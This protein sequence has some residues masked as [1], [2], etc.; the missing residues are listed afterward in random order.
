MRNKIREAI[1]NAAIENDCTYEEAKEIF[2][3]FL[4]IVGWGFSL[5]AVLMF[6]IL[7]VYF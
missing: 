6:T 7:K 1:K 2:I 5:G 4:K 3:I